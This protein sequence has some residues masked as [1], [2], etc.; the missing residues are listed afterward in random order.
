MRVHRR[1]AAV[2]AVPTLALGLALAGCG[3]SDEPE[4]TTTSTSTSSTTTT[5]APATSSTTAAA[6][7]P[8]LGK[9]ALT[10][11][12]VGT[13]DQPVAMTWCTTSGLSGAICT[14]LTSWSVRKAGSTRK[15]R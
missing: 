5:T 15:Q 8:D 7:A 6:A 12:R 13:F 1:A 14:P 2:L 9:I 10:L 11:T 3:G 4:P